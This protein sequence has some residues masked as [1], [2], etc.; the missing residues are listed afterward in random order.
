MLA[1]VRLYVVVGEFGVPLAVVWI[2]EAVAVTHGADR[3]HRG[4]FFAE[5]D[6]GQYFH[7][8][9]R[10][11]VRQRPV[12]FEAALDVRDLQLPIGVVVAVASTQQ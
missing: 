2:L 12:Q 3:G 6:A 9:G 10:H 5:T 7:E 4:E 8:L 11:G 1:D